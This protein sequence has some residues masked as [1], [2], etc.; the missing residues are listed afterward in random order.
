MVSDPW[1]L[2]SQYAV[3]CQPC[4]R[5][6]TK[7]SGWADTVIRIGKDP[8][9]GGAILKN[10]TG[11]RYA[12]HTNPCCNAMNRNNIGCPPASCPISSFNRCE[13]ISIATPSVTLPCQP[14][15]LMHHH[16]SACASSSLPAVP[17]WASIKAGKCEWISTQGPPPPGFKAHGSMPRL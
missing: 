17:F 2:L 8:F 7:K 12:W 16:G 15:T 13:A 9:S 6:R 4:L 11:I 1:L 3:S 5:H 14:V 10:I